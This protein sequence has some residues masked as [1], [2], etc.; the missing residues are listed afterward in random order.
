M[1]ARESALASTRRNNKITEMTDDYF[2]YRGTRYK[3]ESA[4]FYRHNA[5]VLAE[6]KAAQ[7]MFDG[8]NSFRLAENEQ[9]IK[10]AKRY[11]RTS[12]RT[13]SASSTVFEVSIGIRRGDILV[14][15]NPI[16]GRAGSYSGGSVPPAEP[17]YR[18]RA[19]TPRQAF[20]SGALARS[21]LAAQSG[22]YGGELGGVASGA[23][24]YA[25]SGVSAVSSGGGRLD[26]LVGGVQ[27]LA[28][29]TSMGVIR[30]SETG[31][32]IDIG[33]GTGNGVGSTP[34]GDAAPFEFVKSATGDDVL[35]MAARGFGESV[36]AD[37]FY[38]YERDMDIC[39][40]LAGMMGSGM[41]GLALCKQNA[42]Q[43]YQTCRGF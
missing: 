8:V 4:C 39:N 43:D 14:V 6:S 2:H 9:F 25:Q 33:E 42:F 3:L 23:A 15:E 11:L 24:P 13:Q 38:Q 10:H 31:S 41:R 19:M 16:G 17:V 28:T 30:P 32:G 26:A 34:L 40:A 35:S 22:G 29:L 12:N 5:E 27:A 18:P 1:D 37:C 36:E 21:G 20:G 7:E